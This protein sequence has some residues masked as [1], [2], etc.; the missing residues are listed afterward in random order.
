MALFR[1][2]SDNCAIRIS[3]DPKQQQ[4]KPGIRRAIST[5]R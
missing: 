1:G 3:V 5:A 2:N 4:S